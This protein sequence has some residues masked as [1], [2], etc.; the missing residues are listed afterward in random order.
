MG[1][2]VLA[3]ALLSAAL[4][5]GTPTDARAGCVTDFGHCLEWAWSLDSWWD[6]L[7]TADLCYNAYT[8]CMQQKLLGV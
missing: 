4:T 1:R 6:A 3:G 5:L 7:W 8:R 2:K